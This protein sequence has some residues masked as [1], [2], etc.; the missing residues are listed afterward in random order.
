MSRSFAVRAAAALALVA[1][2]GGCASTRLD[3][4]W[5]RPERAG[6][7]IEGPVLV[8]GVARDETIRRVYEDDMVAKL[9]ARGVKSIP[10]YAAVPGA[11]GGDDHQRLLEAAR[12]AGARYL[13]STAVIGQDR[14][15][16]VTQ[17]PYWGW[18]FAGYRGWWGS[19]WG[20]AYPVRTDVRTYNVYVA[21]TALIDVAADRI[22]WTARSRTTEPTQ[23]ERETRVFVDLILEAMTAAGLVKAAK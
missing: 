18:G 2:L 21:Q 13:L 14:E 16:V 7:P 17:D 4:V 20:M 23:V 22:D 19:Y 10:S 8:V 15:V 1:T 9:G 6:Q 11:L 5:T 12:K 3:A